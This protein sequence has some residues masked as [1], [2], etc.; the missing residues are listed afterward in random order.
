M[1]LNI[2]GQTVKVYGTLT[3]VVADNLASHAVG[4]LLQ[5]FSKAFRKCRYCLATDDQIQTIFTDRFLIPRT[6]ETH[7]LHCESLDTT[8]TKHFSTLYGIRSKSVFSPLKYFHII[9]GLVPDIMHDLLEGALP[10]VIC[11]LL[12]DCLEK[13]VLHD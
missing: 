10:L 4:G 11:E 13:E 8:L 6:P 2:K 9:G 3:A 12:L 5:N 7:E 1:D